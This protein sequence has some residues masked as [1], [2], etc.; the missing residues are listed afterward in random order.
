MLVTSEEFPPV[1]EVDDT[2][3]AS[4]NNDFHWLMKVRKDYTCYTTSRHLKTPEMIVQY[5]TLIFIYFYF[6]NKHTD[7]L[8]L[9]RRQS[10]APGHGAQFELVECSLSH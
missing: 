4:V 5:V 6:V 10:P 7:R 1:V 8:H 3:P 9:E 2:Y